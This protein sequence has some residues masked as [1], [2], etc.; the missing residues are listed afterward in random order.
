MARTPFFARI[1]STGG[2]YTVPAGKVAICNAFNATTSSSFFS[3]TGVIGPEVNLYV[4]GVSV[5]GLNFGNRSRHGPLVFNAGDVISSPGS[6]NNPP[7]SIQMSIVGFLYNQSTTKVPLGQKL[8]RASSYTV[9]SNKYIVVNF[10]AGIG[11]ASIRIDGSVVGVTGDAQTLSPS[12]KGE[13]KFGPYTASVSQVI[14]VATQITDSDVFP[15]SGYGSG[16]AVYMN[17]F[18]YNA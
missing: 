10:F 16:D 11:I 18:L 4:N 6:T 9:P 12:V 5:C 15:T 8:T 13:Q 2:T 1:T 17:G 7:T 14:S 3:M